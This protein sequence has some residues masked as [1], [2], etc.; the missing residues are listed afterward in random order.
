MREGYGGTLPVGICYSVYSVV[1][2]SFHAIFFTLFHQLLSSMSLG[3]TLGWL[4][5]QYKA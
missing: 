4:T 5:A 1:E 3:N 2:Q